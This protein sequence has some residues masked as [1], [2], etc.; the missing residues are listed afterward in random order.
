MKYSSYSYNFYSKAEQLCQLR[1][2]RIWMGYS[3]L[4]SN[5]F[6][7][8]STWIRLLKACA[9]F[10]KDVLLLENF[11]IMNYCSISKILKKH[12]KMTGFST[13]EAFMRNVMTNQN[14]TRYPFILELLK[15]CEKLYSDIQNMQNVVPLKSEE[16][17]FLDAIR[18]LNYQASRIQDEENKSLLSEKR[19]CRNDCDNPIESEK[20]S[21]DIMVAF[22][23]AANKVSQT[24][25]ES[26]ESQTSNLCTLLSYESNESLIKKFKSE[27]L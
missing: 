24:I 16:R 2:E 15:E 21:H 17:L 10:Y 26:S 3:I 22:A 18:H 25:H 14:I 8:R 12:D 9:Y 11:A 5:N 13:R 7:D 1:K 4:S 19:E 20:R 6:F 27:P 23:E